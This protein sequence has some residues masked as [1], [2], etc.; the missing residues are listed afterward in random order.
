DICRSWI[1]TTGLH[2]RHHPAWRNA[3][4]S[5]YRRGASSPRV[6]HP[7][8]TLNRSMPHGAQAD[9]NG[10]TEHRSPDE[11]TSFSQCETDVGKM[12]ANHRI[13]HR[14][15]KPRKP[16]IPVFPRDRGLLATSRCVVRPQGLEP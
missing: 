1:G 7:K 13:R 8:T 10:V 14:P 5:N 15:T 4:K 2:H 6:V 16:P 12:W 11:M 9:R 3:I